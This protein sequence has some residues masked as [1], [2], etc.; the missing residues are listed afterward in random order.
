MDVYTYWTRGVG[1]VS[2]QIARI[3]RPS[4]WSTENTPSH[5][6]LLF[7]DGTAFEAHL[8]TGGWCRARYCDLAHWLDV[9]PDRQAWHYA[10]PVPDDAALDLRRKCEAMLG[11]WQYNKMQLLE[12]WVWRRLRR[13]V[14]K[15]WKVVCSEAVGRICFDWYD[16]PVTCGLKPQ[17]FDQLTPAAMLD[18]I[19]PDYK[20]GLPELTPAAAAPPGVGKHS[21]TLETE[22]TN[23]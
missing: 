9:I 4:C 23:A 12:L 15:S 11:L 3:T 1:P 13:P 10:L 21:Q 17:Q 2:R 19:W 16:W 5:T 8:E 18:A 20:E 14:S 7:S 22:E 6:G